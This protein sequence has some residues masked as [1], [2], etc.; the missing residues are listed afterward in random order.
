M[1]D[2]A[3]EDW[4]SDRF[5]LSRDEVLWARQF[6]ETA[7]LSHF[8][9]AGESAT[10]FVSLFEKNPLAVIRLLVTWSEQAALPEVALTASDPDDRADE[11]TEDKKNGTS[12]G[13]PGGN[14]ELP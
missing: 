6:A 10:D 5:D 4:V 8:Q 3:T 9:S 13:S 11:E 12:Q 7:V 2:G 1:L 14:P